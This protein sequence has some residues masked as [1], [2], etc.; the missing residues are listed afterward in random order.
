MQWSLH[1]HSHFS[2]MHA[3]RSAW[4]SLLAQCTQGMLTLQVAVAHPAHS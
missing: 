4:S 3:C 2:V 1:L